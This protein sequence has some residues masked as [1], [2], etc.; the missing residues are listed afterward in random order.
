MD[1]SKTKFYCINLK[2]RPDRKDRM[3]RRFMH[4]EIYSGVEFIEAVPKNSSLV[5]YYGEGI[6]TGNDLDQH[7]G[8]VAC[9]A[10]HLKAIRKML[11]DAG[12]DVPG[13]IICE[14]D[15]LLRNDF[16]E[17]LQI[18]LHNKPPDAPLI[19]LGYYVEYWIGFKW[20][21]LQP[22]QENFCNVVSDHV[23]ATTMYWIS[24]EY[25]FEV[26]QKY[27]QKFRNFDG[28]RTAELI[29]RFSNGHI[30]YPPPCIEDCIGSDVRQD[31][32]MD[33]H[34]RVH[35]GWGY[36]NYSDTEYIHESPLYKVE[37]ERI[38]GEYNP[39]R[40]GEPVSPKQSQYYRM[41]KSRSV[42]S[43][44]SDRRTKGYTKYI[45]TRAGHKQRKGIRFDFPVED[46]RVEEIHGEDIHG[47]DDRVEDIRIEEV[48]IITESG[49]I[50]IPPGYSDSPSMPDENP[51]GALV[52]LLQHDVEDSGEVDILIPSEENIPPTSRVE[53]EVGDLMTRIEILGKE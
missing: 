36:S 53:D 19:C 21:G 9:F 32:G 27:D 31:P 42:H 15:G 14:D 25:A 45:I 35:G 34:I 40:N 11:E 13:G 38:N 4:H 17:R 30:A 46:N 7:R 2:S 6:W 5:D 33:L 1:F 52:D 12:P 39:S 41:I 47:K 23:W 16:F 10:S 8:E 29:T 22:S 43:P 48:P 51:R 26:L 37:C 3:I 49:T 50:I 18:I 20:S 44:T 24:K 28:Y